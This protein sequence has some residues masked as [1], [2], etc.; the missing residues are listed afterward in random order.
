MLSRISH[1]VEVLKGWLL[2]QNSTG[3]FISRIQCHDIVTAPYTCRTGLWLPQADAE[4]NL[5]EHLK[6]IQ[7]EEMIEMAVE[8][9]SG[10]LALPM[11]RGRMESRRYHNLRSWKKFRFLR[12]KNSPCSPL[13]PGTKE[14]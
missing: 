5:C 1:V 12:R 11:A 4:G 10:A 7:P 13:P 8:K 3:L 6:D 14:L 2:C 9:E